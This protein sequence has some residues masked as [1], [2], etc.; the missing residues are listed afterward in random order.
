MLAPGPVAVSLVVDA[1]QEVEDLGRHLLSRD[2]EFL[3]QLALGGAANSLDGRVQPD[4]GLGG[5]VERMR[6]A[7]VGPHSC[8]SESDPAKKK[9]KIS[10]PP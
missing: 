5:D 8:R 7:G 2:A 10:N 1:S 6:A 3:V 4:A 9:E